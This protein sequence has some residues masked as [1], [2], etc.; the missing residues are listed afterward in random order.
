MDPDVQ[1]QLEQRFEELP[2]VVQ[3]AITSSDVEKK[4][5][6]VADNHKLHLDQWGKLELEVRLTLFAI[7]NPADLTKNIQEKVGVSAEEA[8]A[9]ANDINTIVFEPMRQ[10]LERQLSSP[11][12]KAKEITPEEAAGQQ[13]IASEAASTQPASAPAVIP[14]TPP[15]PPP[16]EKAVRAPISSSY[17]SRQ[18]ST[19]RKIADGDPYR[20]L[21]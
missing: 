15:T 7:E 11:E 6:A 3:D 4:L 21:P 12:A 13:A 1:K 9:L 16:T 17:T 18:P 8:A 5:R 2:Q 10:E 19:E 20:E 14:A